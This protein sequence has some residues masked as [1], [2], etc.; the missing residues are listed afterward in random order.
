MQRGAVAIFG[1]CRKW[2]TPLQATCGF[3]FLGSKRTNRRHGKLALL[4]LSG[5]LRGRSGSRPAPPRR[6]CADEPSERG[7]SS[8][9]KRF[10][11]RKGRPGPK[12]RARLT[13]VGGTV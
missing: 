13:L 11:A 4:T 5:H 12:R 7:Q 2:V 1:P 3:P 6:S 10:V 8:T 9:R